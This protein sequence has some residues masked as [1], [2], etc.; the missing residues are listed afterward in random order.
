MSLS[1][2]HTASTTHRAK[3]LRRLAACMLSMSLLCA[4]LP[5]TAHAHA[6]ANGSELS[7]ASALSIAVPL[8]MSAA[9]PVMLVAGV[10]VMTVAAVQVVADGTVW[11]L[12]RASDGAKFSVKLSATTA[13]AA[14]VAVGTAVTVTAV[15]AGWVLSVAGEVLALIP[16]ELC[17]ALLHHERVIK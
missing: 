8:T 14:S 15:S 10:S 4:G 7:E 9:A 2:T 11:V 13:G 5:T 12:T 6:H 3:P 1:K 16:N 17:K